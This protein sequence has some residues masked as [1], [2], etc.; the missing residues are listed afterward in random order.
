[1]TRLLP[2]YDIKSEV[3]FQQI[4]RFFLAPL[5]QELIANH[6]KPSQKNRLHLTG[7][8]FARLSLPQV[9]ASGK[10][11]FAVPSGRPCLRPP[12]AVTP[13]RQKNKMWRGG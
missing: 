3:S 12:P 1:L 8:F 11:S 5:A 13:E 10:G 4:L 6:H 7:V 2:Q 9:E